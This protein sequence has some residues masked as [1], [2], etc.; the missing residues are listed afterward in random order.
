MGRLDRPTGFGMCFP[1][2]PGR[3]GGFRP[4]VGS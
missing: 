1:P 3:A 2:T 4:V